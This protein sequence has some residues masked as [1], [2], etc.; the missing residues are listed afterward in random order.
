MKKEEQAK[1]DNARVR[2]MLDNLPKIR[3]QMA[4]YYDDLRKIEHDV[5]AFNKRFAAAIRAIYEVEQ[6]YPG[7]EKAVEEKPKNN[8]ILF[9]KRHTE[10]EQK[11]PSPAI[12]LSTGGGADCPGHLL[13]PDQ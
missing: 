11:T 5:Y 1:I 6:F 8:I 12:P 7:E 3:C 13:A 9:P 2:N 10:P 4:G